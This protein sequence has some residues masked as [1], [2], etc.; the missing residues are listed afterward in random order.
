MTLLTEFK[1][2]TASLARLVTAAMTSMLLLG[3]LVPSGSGGT[4]D[5]FLNFSNTPFV[6]PRPTIIT[7]DAPGGGTGPGQG[8]ITFA[9]NPAGTISGRY[10]DAGS[11]IHGF[12]R[13][14]DGAIVT[15]DAPGAGTGPRQGTRP[16]S[17]NPA[18]V[19]AGYYNDA[20]NVFHG[21][22]RSRHGV[23]TIFNIPGAGTG[24][25]QGTFAG[26]INPEEVIAGRYVDTSDV[27]HGFLRA[28]N[29]T[30]TTFDAP[31]AGT[32][33]GQ[34]TFVFTGYCLNPTG[35]IA[36]ASL[37][38]SDVYHGFLRTPDGTITTFDV[39][40]AGTGPFQGTIPL[41]NN[42]ADAITGYYIDANDVT[43]GFLRTP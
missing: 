12:V 40:G 39:P 37:D 2:K 34:G 8:T 26:N 25:G 35:A 15:F 4:S 29:G 21:F 6:C 28:P 14:R 16:F 3:I 24:P 36:G 22:L 27:A 33:A 30:I 5:G 32:G 18:G 9:I 7:F 13:T 17:I 42:P 43:H 11:A 41:S 10:A 19:S 20:S 31:N 38:S 23:I 1:D